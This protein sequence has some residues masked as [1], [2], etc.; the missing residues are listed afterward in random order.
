MMMIDGFAIER[1]DVRQPAPLR[2]P[3]GRRAPVHAERA[4]GWKL[5]R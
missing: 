2:V 3:V 1:T 5:V 4:G